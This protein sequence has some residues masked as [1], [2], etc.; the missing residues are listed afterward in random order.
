MSQPS[1]IAVSRAGLYVHLPFCRTLCPYC[2]FAVVRD[3]GEHAAYVDALVSAIASDRIAPPCDTLYVGGGT[4]SR[5]DDATLATVAEAAQQLRAGSVWREATLEVNPE[6]V[7]EARLAAWWAA[8]FDRLS[9]GVQRL[10]TAGLKRLGRA[11]S[12]AAIARL[13]RLL[14]HWCSLGGRVSVDLIYGLADDTPQAIGAQVEALLSWPISHL[15]AYHLT[16]EPGTP[17]ARGVETGAVRVCDA[18]KA[19]ALYAAILA[20]MDAAG[21]DAYEVSN[22]AAPGARAVHNWGYWAGDAYVG[23]GLGAVSAWPTS[24]GWQRTVRHRDYGRYLVA[25]A[26][27]AAHETLDPAM[28]R[29]ERLLLGLRSD[30]GVPAAWVE[31]WPAGVAVLERLKARGDAVIS[32]G[33]FKLRAAARLLADELAARWAAGWVGDDGARTIELSDSGMLQ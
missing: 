21:W 29:S 24:A 3:R 2:D 27:V 28:L 30:V 15:S 17:F 7:C 4:P 23:H 14:Q 20:V 12:A 16:I 19:A 6:D 9:I 25:P 22:F 1:A 32:G 11:R 5:L 33:R 10:D 13:P 8:G 18:D 26:A 31:H